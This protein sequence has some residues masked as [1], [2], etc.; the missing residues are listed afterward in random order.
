MDPFSSVSNRILNYLNKKFLIDCKDSE[1]ENF[2]RA[3]KLLKKNGYLEKAFEEITSVENIGRKDLDQAIQ[4]KEEGNIF[5]QQEKF[6]ESLSCYNDSIML[7]PCSNDFDIEN[8]SVDL[9]MCLTNRATVLGIFK[10]YENAA[11]D[12]EIAVKSG[13]PK[14]SLYK[15]YQ[16]LAVSYER[17]GN[18]N[19]AIIAYEKLIEVLDVSDLSKD[20]VENM[21]NEIRFS[22]KSMKCEKATEHDFR[23]LS[24]K[25]E[26]PEIS[27]FSKSIAIKETNE[28]GRHIVAKDK[29]E[30]GNIISREKA[31]VSALVPCKRR[32]H[33]LH[34]YQEVYFSFFSNKKF[35]TKNNDCF[36]ILSI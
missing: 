21:K 34:C 25:N 22:L 32:S 6:S 2:A 12:L 4:L 10:M 9:A 18:Q 27:T 28:K 20:K 35:Y 33:C 1:D 14:N 16:L 15:I 36:F 23:K 11:E 5:F 7:T 17:L 13:Y 26:H 30:V 31:M 29:I 3:Y 24:L 19:K 8:N